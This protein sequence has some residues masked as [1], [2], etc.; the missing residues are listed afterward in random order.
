MQSLPTSTHESVHTRPPG[1]CTA[2]VKRSFTQNCRESRQVR[3]AE[4]RG[5][6]D[7][8]RTGRGF[9]A[10]PCTGAIDGLGGTRAPRERSGPRRGGAEAPGSAS[11]QEPHRAAAR[12]PRTTGCR[13]RV[14]HPSQ[15]A[16][17]GTTTKRLR[18]RTRPDHHQQLRCSRQQ[19]GSKERWG[20]GLGLRFAH[21]PESNRV[22]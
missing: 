9:S 19:L 11:A 8:K 16:V 18:A 2:R 10:A 22:L 17:R 12:A 3:R 4:A 13:R 7:A 14:A 1:G 6:A 21:P 5:H 15:R 20:R